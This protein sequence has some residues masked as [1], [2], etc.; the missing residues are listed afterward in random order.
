MAYL[1]DRRPPRIFVLYVILLR[2]FQVKCD[3]IDDTSEATSSMPVSLPIMGPP[4]P[5]GPPGLKGD[6]GQ[7][8]FPGVPG[9][10]GNMLNSLK[11]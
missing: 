11:N 4:G 9:L 3:A 1:N 8:G 10:P 2:H 7:P 6:K 5:G